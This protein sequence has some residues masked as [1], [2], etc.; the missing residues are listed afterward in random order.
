M[1]AYAPI[2]VKIF[3]SGAI[4]LH[5]K[6][7]FLRT[8]ILARSLF[9]AHLLTAQVAYIRKLNAV[10]ARVLRRVFGAPR[11]DSTKGP[12]DLVVRVAVGMPSLDCLLVVRRLH[13]VARLVKHRPSQLWALLQQRV[14]DRPLPWVAQLRDDFMVFFKCSAAVRSE[15]PVPIGDL[16]LHRWFNFV[17]DE[18]LKWGELVRN[19]FFYESVLDRHVT[20][21]APVRAILTHKCDV[22]DLYF[23]TRKG[24]DQHKRR[25]HGV[26]SDMRFFA[27]TDGVC[28]ACK[29]V[30]STRL[31]LLAHLTDRRRDYCRGYILAN[32][33]PL[34]ASE[35]QAL[36]HVDRAAR[37]LA[38]R[39]GHSHPIAVQSA[40]TACGK[41]IGRVAC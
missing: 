29:T 33:S 18:P 13:Y 16:A 23:S 2:A 34:H 26:L 8:L 36:D 28:L 1:A 27:R 6:L 25:K 21:H 19:V 3:G 38:H 7:H 4:G 22:C 11:H 30:F 12:T 32:S 35:V 9:N 10:Y 41:R 24:L 40:R 39:A 5:V 31:R 15:L 20:P 17:N 37:R 14:S